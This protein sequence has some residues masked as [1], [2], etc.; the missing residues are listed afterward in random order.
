M[1]ARI[2][3]ESRLSRSSEYLGTPHRQACTVN[4]ARIA[5]SERPSTEKALGGGRRD[6]CVYSWPQLYSAFHHQRR[7]LE[8][9]V[10][11]IRHGESAANAAGLVTGAWDVPL[12]EHGRAQA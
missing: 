7:Q 10:D 4:P 1:G 12:T 5:R 2:D 9:Q 3:E 6:A 8:L 11:F